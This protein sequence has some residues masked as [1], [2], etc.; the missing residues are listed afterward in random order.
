MIFFN[1]CL[2]MF[3]AVLNS[4]RSLCTSTDILSDPEK[5]P[6]EACN[7]VNKRKKEPSSSYKK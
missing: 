6:E 2:F 1:D 4:L 3:I 5:L 7:A